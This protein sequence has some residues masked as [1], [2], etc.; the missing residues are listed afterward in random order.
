MKILKQYWHLIALVSI[1]LGLSGVIFIT[2]QKLKEPEPIA[3][4]VPQVKPKAV[5]PACT[6]TFNIPTP[7]ATPTP[8]PT[9]T[10][11][12][13]PNPT[14]TP[15][16]TP[17]PTATP[18]PSKTP[19]PLPT[20]TPTPTSTVAPTPK[21]PVAGAGPSVLGISTIVA[22]VALLFLGLVL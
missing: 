17:G 5:V 9:A 2:T 12:P 18:T 1:S 19:T 16:P 21:V 14:A 13:T 6:V 11:T 20:P 4:T 8:T 10:P 22:G 15:T 7:T 3:P